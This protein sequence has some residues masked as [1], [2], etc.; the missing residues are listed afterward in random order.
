MEAPWGWL[1]LAIFTVV[2][3]I[4][5]TRRDTIVRD[6]CHGGSASLSVIFIAHF[7]CRL[8]LQLPISP[9]LLFTI[10]SAVTM[11]DYL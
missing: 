5:V 7:L 10:P 6:Q 4:S 2:I 8:S 11:N 9:M 3:V 1:S